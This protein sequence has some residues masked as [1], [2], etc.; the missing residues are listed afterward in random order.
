VISI[1]PS[2]DSG[3]CVREMATAPS[4]VYSVLALSDAAVFV[5]R[6]LFP[7]TPQGKEKRSSEIK[8]HV[9]LLVGFSL[10]KSDT[11]FDHR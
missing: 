3:F 10:Y 8:R 9:K 4:H 1:F 6:C 7:P 2:A 5:V 11:I